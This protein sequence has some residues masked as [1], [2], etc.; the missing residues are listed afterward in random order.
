MQASTLPL[1]S[2]RAASRM[3]SWGYLI[4]WFWL[5]YMFVFAFAKFYSAYFL[6]PTFS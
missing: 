4:D 2:C 5:L 3:R 6:W 1:L